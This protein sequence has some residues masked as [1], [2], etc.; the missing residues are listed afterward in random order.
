[1][2]PGV[3]SGAAAPC[4]VVATALE[5]CRL[6]NMLVGDRAA[7]C[8]LWWPTSASA[9]PSAIVAGTCQCCLH[10]VRGFLFAAAAVAGAYSRLS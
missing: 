10:G 5:P 6:R 9:A 7:A 4:C 3:S 8:Y 2:T 1:V